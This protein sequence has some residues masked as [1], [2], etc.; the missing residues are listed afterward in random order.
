MLDQLMRI[1]REEPFKLL[2]DEIGDVYRI[3]EVEI[4]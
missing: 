1:D 3:S 2:G 4:S